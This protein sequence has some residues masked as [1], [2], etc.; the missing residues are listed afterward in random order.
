M[1]DIEKYLKETVNIQTLLSEINSELPQLVAGLSGS[2][3]N[4]LTNILF[5]ELQKTIVVL[6]PNLLQATQVYEDISQMAPEVPLYIFPVEESVAAELAFSSP[7]YRSQRVETL[8][9]LN[10]GKKGIVVIPAA[11]FKKI[12]SPASIWETHCL[13]FSVGMELDMDS[14]PE[15]LVAMGYSRERMVA[16]PG[17]FSIRGGIIDI[18][19]L[20]EENPLRMELFDT[21]IDTL[22]YF[23][24]YT[25]KSV[26]S[27]ETVRILPAQ[28]TIFTKAEIVKQA[29]AVEKKAEKAIKGIK[30][31]EVKESMTRVFSEL[32]DNMKRG[33]L[34][35]DP[36]LYTS[37]VYPEQPT[38]LDYIS[39]DALLIVDD[40]SRMLEVERTIES[41]SSEWKMSKV[42]E[43]ICLPSQD[44]SA[45]IR[46]VIKKS[47]Q[48]RIYYALFHRGFG[49]MRF[50]GVYPFQ[51]RTLN[52]FFSQMPQV[53]LEMERWLKQH[54]TV[55]VMVPSFE[56]AEKVQRIFADFGVHSYIK[57]N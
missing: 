19:A 15:K 8:D 47:K 45:D 31:Q 26:D 25:Q 6:T 16:S 4:L 3:R 24:A 18:Y 54:M 57:G 7:E 38:I 52:N 10:S 46:E 51:Y 36:Q 55:F 29:S 28:D 32:T 41:E 39:E 42:S 9:F 40:Y 21:E 48:H 27:I 23:D 20:N 17:E 49:N 35:K 2:G 22:R 14:L 43:G 33:E 30:N 50:H 11:G 34:S 53:K 37:L 44:F 12:L 56:R 1:K 5:E 13:D